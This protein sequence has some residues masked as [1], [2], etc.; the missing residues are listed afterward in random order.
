MASTMSGITALCGMRPAA[1]LHQ[2]YCEMI[3]S[4]AID[5]K[6]DSDN[7]ADE[8]VGHADSVT[9]AV[10]DTETEADYLWDKIDAEKAAEE[11]FVVHEDS[12]EGDSTENPDPVSLFEPETKQSS[13]D[14]AAQDHKSALD[15]YVSKQSQKEADAKLKSESL[16]TAAGWGNFGLFLLLAVIFGYFIGHALDGIFGTKPILTIFWVCCGIAAAVRELVRTIKA[17]SKLGDD[18]AK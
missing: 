3:S 4:D 11:D 1:A 9:E 6:P 16:K 10:P 17:A 13:A 14:N 12:G 18:D 15:N 8:V 7:D 5:R 2:R